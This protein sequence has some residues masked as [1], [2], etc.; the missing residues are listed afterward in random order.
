MSK[1]T[2]RTQTDPFPSIDA[3]QLSKVAGGASRVTARSNSG[4]DQLTLMLTQIT[5]SIKALSQNNSQSDPMQMMMMMMMMGGMGGGG[6]AV[7][8]PP[9]APAPAPAPVINISTTV[10]HRGW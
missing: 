9:P 3:T 10:R 5:D 4:N 7:A 6:G 8:A 2:Q 1:P